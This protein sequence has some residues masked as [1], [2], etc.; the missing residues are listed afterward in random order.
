MKYTH[1]QWPGLDEGLPPTPTEH[2]AIHELLD[3]AV[4]GE[5]TSKLA[6]QI[7]IAFPAERERRKARDARAAR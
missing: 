1:K 7:A 2:Y 4:R 5:D 6:H 3:R